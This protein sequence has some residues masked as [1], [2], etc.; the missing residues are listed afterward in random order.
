[1]KSKKLIITVTLT[2]LVVIALLANHFLKSPNTNNH[3]DDFY[4]K[5]SLKLNTVI[6]ITVYNTNESLAILKD[7]WSINN[8]DTNADEKTLYESIIDEAFNLVDYY[9]SLFSRTI[10]TSDIYQ[11]NHR[12]EM[13]LQVSSDTAE[14]IDYGLYYSKLTNGKFDISI[15]TLTSLWNF[16]MDHPALPNQSDINEAIKHVNYR[17]LHQKDTTLYADDI[18]LQIDLGAIAKGYIADELKEFLI[19]KGIT[20]A[21]I[22]LGGNVLCIGSKPDGS[23][24]AVGVQKPFSNQ[25]EV[26]LA[27]DITNLSVVS[28]GTY[29]RYFTIDG[30]QYHHILDP[31]TG[32]P[33]D[34]NLISVTIISKKSVDGDGLS[35]S[36]F[37]LG[38][39]QGMKLIN[40]LD[41][42]Y[43]IFVTKDDQIFYSDG[44]EGKFNIRKY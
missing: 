42:T 32:Y 25:G 18:H 33:Y 11:F 34:N 3:S 40:S 23:P 19:S 6:T 26:L 39:D 2:T 21:M 4:S 22:N 14:L 20:S 8:K 13:S 35:T 36:C 5:S 37:A 29:E 44:L 30:K 31:K 1:M 12:S 28:S 7:A 43:A 10:P 38:L 41:D 24:F 16:S 27:L 9:E 15:G 17:N